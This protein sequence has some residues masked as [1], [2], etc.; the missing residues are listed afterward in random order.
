VRRILWCRLRFRNHFC[1]FAVIEGL[2][3]FT[4]WPIF[5]QGFD[6]AFPYHPMIFRG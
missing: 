3:T 6:P 2:K 5:I 1:F 4:A